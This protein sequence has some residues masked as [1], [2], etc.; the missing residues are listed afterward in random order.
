[1]GRPSLTK[2]NRLFED[3]KYQAQSW[4]NDRRLVAKIEWRLGELF[5][6]V[7]FIV[8]N[9]P[10]EPDRVLRFCNRRGTAE[11]HIKEGKYAFH[12][13]RLSCRR[14]RD[15][16]VRLQLHA[17]AYNLATRLRCIK[18]LRPCSIGL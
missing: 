4:A 3:F 14:F 8:T 17:L 12:W 18:R 11:Q 16:E 10:M 15:T 13:T 1:V 5:S 9:L 6:R 7:G 2:V